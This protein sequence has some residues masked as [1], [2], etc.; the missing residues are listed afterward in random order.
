MEVQQNIWKYGFSEFSVFVKKWQNHYIKWQKMRQFKNQ[1]LLFLF[2]SPVLLGL[3]KSTIPHFKALDQLFWPL[4][5][6]LTLEAI[7][8]AWNQKEILI[9][10]YPFECTSIWTVIIKRL[11]K[12][13]KMVMVTLKSQ[14][15]FVIYKWASLIMQEII[16]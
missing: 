6:L 11:W 14:R 2:I 8:Y 12:V 16:K 3:Q 4:A 10:Y 5:W 15:Y 13:K 9:K 7:H 1:H